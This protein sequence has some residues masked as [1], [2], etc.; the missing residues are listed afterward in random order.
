MASEERTVR[1]LTATLK[2]LEQNEEDLKHQL[3]TTKR[4]EQRTEYELRRHTEAKGGKEREIEKTKASAEEDGRA[5]SRRLE[6]QERKARS[7][8]SEIRKM[9]SEID[10]L[11]RE[12]R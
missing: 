8:E 2:R 6:E 5:A 7:L 10:S 12:I 3:E 11:K 9:Q 1:E 4:D